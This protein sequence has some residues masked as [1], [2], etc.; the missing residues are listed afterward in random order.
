MAKYP[1]GAT[2][3]NWDKHG[4]MPSLLDFAGIVGDGVNDD[5]AGIN[6]AIADVIAAGGLSLLIPGGYTFLVKSPITLPAG[7]L[8]L[9]LLGDGDSSIVKRGANMPAGKGVLDISG[10]QVTLRD[11]VI[12][13]DVTVSA[14]VNYSAF[15]DPMDAQLTGNSSIWAHGGIADLL[16]DGVRIYHSGGY[17]V[18]LDATAGDIVGVRI[19]GCTLRNN[20]PHL[21]GTSAL[22]LSYGSWTGGIHYQGD[23]TS[24][25]VR[26]L[27]VDG[28]S[29]QRGTGNQVWGHA[30]A[31][32]KMHENVRVTNN[33]FEDIGRDGVQLAATIGGLVSNN[34]GRRIG[35]IASDDTSAAQPKYLAGQYAVFID[36]SGTSG[37]D[38]TGNTCISALGAFFDLDGFAY[39]RV[40]GNT[41]R[42]PSATDPE[43]TEDLI[44]SWPGNY[45][46]GVQT[47]NN[48][49]GPGGTNVSITDNT[50][51]NCN[52]GAIRLFAAR[53]CHV[54]GNTVSHPAAAVFA[55]IILGNF[56]PASG[57]GQIDTA[58]CDVAGNNIQ[59]SPA[60]AA[61]AIQELENWGAGAMPWA[62]ETN[63]V[64]GN[65][66]FGANVTEFSKAPSSA[67]IA[68]V[69]ISNAGAMP[70]AAGL[71]SL[72]ADSS[73]LQLSIDGGAFK[74]VARVAGAATH[75]QFN[76]AT[77]LNL[78]GSADL[79]WDD[80]GKVLTVGGAAG[81][82]VS[83]YAFNSRATGANVGFQ[84]ANL[85]F[86]VDGNGNV[87]SS[88]A[89]SAQSFTLINGVAPARSA[90]YSYLYADASGVYVSVNGAA[91]S[92]LLS[93]VGVNREVFFNDSGAM[94]ANANLQF[95]KT[96]N[97][98]TVSGASSSGVVANVF[99]S[100]AIGSNPAFQAGGTNF[101]VDGNGNVSTTQTVAAGYFTLHVQSAPATA[102]GYS[103]LYMGAAAV[104]LSFNGGAWAPLATVA[105][106]DKQIQFN[107][108]GASG[109]SANLTWDN[110]AQVLTIA[111]GA[112]TGVAAYA[113]SS[114]ATGAG[115]GFQLASSKFLVDGNGNVTS[116][117][118]MTAKS[119]VLQNGTAPA[120]SAGFA[121]LYADASGLYVSINGGAFA[122]LPVIAGS[123]TQIQYNNG[124]AFGASS[125]L[126]WNGAQLGVTGIGTG[127]AAIAVTSGYVS[128]D[129]GFA[130]SSTS[131]SAV[132][133][134][135]GTVQAKYLTAASTV[136]LVDPGTTPSG[137]SAGNMALHYRAGSGL[138]MSPN[139]GAWANIVNNSNAWI[140]GGGVLCPHAASIAGGNFYVTKNSD[141]AYIAGV[142]DSFL[143]QGGTRRYFV[144][145]IYIG[146]TSIS[147]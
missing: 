80:T 93:V 28:C 88:A 110:T 8:N 15:S 83:S 115:I 91:F 95:D 38:Y 19:T 141:T 11:F 74:P 1:H 5:A 67:S 50:F 86:L 18:L 139:G 37:V 68:G 21:F 42:V 10:S 60:A 133:V 48:Y 53:G 29:F 9:T 124:G 35:Y 47:A 84:L 2:R 121:Y 103:Y 39:G 49:Y 57:G 118:A 122:S 81:S 70:S 96:F 125:S 126:T 131:S 99:N 113:F 147:R 123:S 7:N 127:F 34:A 25:R 58:N 71:A 102:V 52:Y 16:L 104:Y 43:Y 4:E 142:D 33:Q 27:M 79:T 13:G 62:G 77:G 59:W 31:F 109:A 73:A 46:Y 116:S 112:A 22:D 65:H 145:G 23:G 17:A 51:I 100:S 41:C 98:L 44:S 137:S 105:G 135:N 76:D 64:A 111:G 85:K 108:A 36:T 132:N 82:G 78:A 119:F 32:T 63:W 66:I 45:T 120:R 146:T 20:R 12:E 117:A 40:S 24:H 89:V 30:Y 107:N 26:N 130:T 14:G 138:W 134:P 143:D 69:L 106:A 114:Q 61:A 94:G 92:P 128:A 144:G 6:N 97:V 56:V 3:R 75:I 87:T 136:Y 140:S 90:G 72:K 101:L 54:T 55:P 129:G